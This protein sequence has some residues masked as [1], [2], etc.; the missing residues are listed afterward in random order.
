MNPP[1]PALADNTDF[2]KLPEPLADTIIV[3]DRII[4]HCGLEEVTDGVGPILPLK[5][6]RP[7]YVEAGWVRLWKAPED[8][9]ID[10]LFHL[11]IGGPG[12]DMNLMY[13]MTRADSPIPHFLM[14][15]NINPPA[16]WSYHIDLA[17]K[18]D[19]VM[20]PDYWREAYTPLSATTESKKIKSIP[21]SRIQADRKQY[22]STWGMYGK[23]VEQPEYE[24]V[25]DKVMPVY[26]DHFLHLVD[27]FSF[28]QVDKQYLTQ[29]GGHLM[30]MLLA[31]E[32]DVKGWGRFDALFGAE[33][34]DQVRELCRRELKPAES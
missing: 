18:V 3:R 2:D 34:T 24:M 4:E 13:A 20:Y 22:L 28:D 7:P 16:I 15:Y 32:M 10:R 12:N 17:P 31:R 9:V 19:G 30:D 14:H 33:Q 25:R 27:N 11:Y 6:R 29:R 1:Q 5:L 26:L 23:E 21:T 8:S